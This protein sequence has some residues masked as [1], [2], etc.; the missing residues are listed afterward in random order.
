MGRLLSQDY[1]YIGYVNIPPAVTDLVYDQDTDV[2]TLT[3]SNASELTTSIPVPDVHLFK[4]TGE[5]SPTGTLSD[6]TAIRTVD[7]SLG[8]DG[9]YQTLTPAAQIFGLGSIAIA[10][11]GTGIPASGTGTV[12]ASIVAPDI[13]PGDNIQEYGIYFLNEA[14]EPED[15]SIVATGGFPSN[16]TYGGVVTIGP[17]GYRSYAIVNGIVVNSVSDVFATPVVA[18][19]V[20]YVGFDRSNNKLLV[21][22]GSGAVFNG[23]Q[24]VSTGFPAGETYFVSAYASFTTSTPTLSVGSIS[25]DLSCSDGGKNPIQ[26]IGSVDA[27]AGA[28]EGREYIVTASGTY[29][30]YELKA[31]DVVKF[32]N[33]IN[34]LTISRLPP[35]TTDDIPPGVIS[36]GYDA[37]TQ[38]LAITRLFANGRTDNISTLIETTSASGFV[39]VK[40]ITPQ[41]ITDNVGNKVPDT[42]GYAITSCTSGTSAIRVHVLATTGS[43]TLK[44]V[45]TVNGTEVT[46]LA[47]AEARSLWEGYVDLTIS[48]DVVVTVLHSEGASNTC[49]VTYEAP[50]E[51]SLAT[52]VDTYPAAGQTQY[53]AADTVHIRVTS[54]TPFKAIQARSGA[55]YAT[56]SQTSTTFDA[57]TDTSYGFA[58]SNLGNTTQ[59]LPAS[60]RIRN[61]NGTWGPWYSTD[62]TGSVDGVN[63]ISLNN[64]RPSLAISS[65]TYPDGQSAIKSPETATVHVTYSNC[66]AVLW[67]A[68]TGQLT[69]GDPAVLADPVVSIAAGGL[70]AYNIGTNNLRAVVTRTANNTSATFNTIVWIADAAPE[71]TVTVP[72]VR[73]QSDVVAKA[74]VIT[75]SASP[76]RLASAP[77]LDASKG[78]WSGSWGTSNSGITWTRTLLISDAETKGAATF[79][80]L[81][82][83][84]L[85]GTTVDAISS[86]SS[87]TVAG[88]VRRVVTFEAYPIAQKRYTAIGT[89]VYD[90]SKVRVTN[91]GKTSTSGAWTDLYVNSL[92]DQVDRF[93]IVDSSGV[94]SATGDH[95]YNNDLDNA[96][97]NSSGTLQ[98]EIEEII[99]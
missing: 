69:I 8:V 83:T 62:T 9:A 81:L 43:L 31:H 13:Q 45:I 3:N 7:A 2:L 75:L 93:T 89:S 55:G 57:T 29:R 58:V 12:W 23:A 56:D 17:T 48:G 87:Y 11:S 53:A 51:V 37:G 16:K 1:P 54:L 46:N 74:H 71:I 50:P 78:S 80:N 39:C 84:N 92:V 38:Q 4:T 22:K 19:D 73:L 85:A 49:S 14:C 33:G 86:G 27:P 77:T 30:G 25:F 34:D 41:N 10:S 28:E 64:T 76:Q 21:Q 44:P 15:F 6:A 40:D 52:F 65:I 95:V 36:V 26:A 35:V 68:P 24:L 18:G 97:V 63:V 32:Y 60:V 88:F 98:F 91:L 47:A 42:S 67:T 99:Q 96:V 82:A 70:G 5:W 61:V 59:S 94:L 72:A 20:V 66:D 79:S 90:T